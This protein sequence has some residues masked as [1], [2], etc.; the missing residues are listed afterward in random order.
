MRRQSQA[1]KAVVFYTPSCRAPDLVECGDWLDSIRMQPGK[2][3]QRF[4]HNKTSHI[5]RPFFVRQ[6]LL[7]SRFGVEGRSGKATSTLCHFAAYFVR[8][9]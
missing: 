5:L 7:S 1:E 9:G 2:C 4:M 8:S 3:I 6:G